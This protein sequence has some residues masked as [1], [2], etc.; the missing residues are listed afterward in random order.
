MCTTHFL[1]VVRDPAACLHE[2]ASSGDTG[3][4]FLP[5][6][7]GGLQNSVLVSQL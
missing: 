2:E 7:S 5:D 1:T 6:Q 4:S 3:L